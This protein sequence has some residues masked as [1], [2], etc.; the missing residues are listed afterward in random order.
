MN[1]DDLDLRAVG[2]TI[3][4]TGAVFADAERTYLCLFPKENADQPI[5][6]L[7]MNID[8]WKAFLRQTDILETEVVGQT[9]EGIGKIILRK[10]QR[11]ISSHVQWTCFKRDGYRCR[12]C[13]QEGVPLTV[14]HAVAWEE[15]GPSTVDNLVTAC[16]QCNKIR[17]NTP[18]DRW[19]THPYY[20][21]VSRNLIMAATEANERLAH[22]LPTIPRMVHKP[23]KR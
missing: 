3:R 22:R 12:Y 18:Y 1:F 14:D 20:R 7:V 16:R 4:M 19:L 9:P 21:K 17:G 6:P 10:S 11:Q 15:G 2:N 13:G 8:G 5:E 23:K